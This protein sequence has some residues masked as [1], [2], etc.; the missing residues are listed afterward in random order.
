M[1]RSVKCKNQRIPKADP[2]VIKNEAKNKKAV[3]EKLLLFKSWN[4]QMEREGDMGRG[5]V[6]KC[7]FHP[8]KCP[9][10]PLKCPFYPMELPGLALHKKYAV[11]H[12]CL[13]Q[14]CLKLR[15]NPSPCRHPKLMTVYTATS[16]KQTALQSVV[17]TQSLSSSS[18]PLFACIAL[19]FFI[20]AMCNVY[21]H[22]ITLI[23]CCE[24][25]CKT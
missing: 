22:Y 12:S 4:H 2:K 18:P 20:C 9:S 19:I 3:A 16:F 11:S 8:I 14:S 13:H 10:Y 5:Y 23:V 6:Y 24:C 15:I 17:V 7:P 25:W 21:K 1:N